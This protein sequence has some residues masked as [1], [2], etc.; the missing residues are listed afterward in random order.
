MKCK[1]P[2]GSH[3][4]Y[5]LAYFEFLKQQTH[6]KY[7]LSATLNR[8]EKIK[9]MRDGERERNERRRGKESKNKR[10]RDRKRDK[11]VNSVTI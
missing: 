1:Q 2:V 5:L 9:K 11:V 4:T 3:A 7:Q 6:R 8:N 10:E